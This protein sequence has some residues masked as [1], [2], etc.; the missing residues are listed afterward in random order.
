[1]VGG[2]TNYNTTSS[3][4][5][6]TLQCSI[7]HPIM[8]PLRL[9]PS[10]RHRHSQDQSTSRSPRKRQ[11][12]ASENSHPANKMLLGPINKKNHHATLPGHS[13]FP[14]LKESKEAVMRKANLCYLARLLSLVDLL[15]PSIL[16]SRGSDSHKS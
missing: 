4:A 9:P 7:L 14:S 16:D 11:K 3:L 10:V 6:V 12:K 1:V 5:T 2:H 8:A 15:N 13:K